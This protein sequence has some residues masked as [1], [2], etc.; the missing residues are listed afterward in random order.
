MTLPKNNRRV[1]IH[2]ENGENYLLLKQFFDRGKGKVSRAGQFVFHLKNAH[3][4]GGP[5]TPFP[6]HLS[7]VIRFADQG[8]LNLSYNVITGKQRDSSA[9]VPTEAGFGKIAAHCVRICV[10]KSFQN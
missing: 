9:D 8:L 1:G 10:R 2:A 4:I 7:G 3:C 5:F 6:I